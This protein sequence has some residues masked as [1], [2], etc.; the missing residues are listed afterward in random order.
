MWSQLSLV[1][2]RYASSCRE[3][4]FIRL[5]SN[6]VTGHRAH[7]QYNAAR[8]RRE[9]GLRC[10]TESS[11]DGEVG[12]LFGIKIL[13]HVF[14]HSESQRYVKANIDGRLCFIVNTKEPGLVK[15]KHDRA[16]HAFY[17]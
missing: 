8:E 17:H 7:D 9:I 16:H 13:K 10:R 5:T 3:T 6:L 1:A 11:G 2:R 4:R 15:G 12:S 14:I